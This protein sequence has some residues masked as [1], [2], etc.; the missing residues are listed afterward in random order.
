MHKLCGKSNLSDDSYLVVD[1]G[2][3]GKRSVNCSSNDDRPCLVIYGDGSGG[4][5]VEAFSSHSCTTELI[6]HW[7]LIIKI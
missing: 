5:L 4:G 7:D 3:D 1:S 6:V 2:S